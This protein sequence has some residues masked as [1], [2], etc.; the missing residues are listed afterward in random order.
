MNEDGSGLRA[1][2]GPEGMDE[3]PSWSPDGRSIAYSSNNEAIY[4]IDVEGGPRRRLT[5]V[6]FSTTMPAWRPA[7][8]EPTE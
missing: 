7:L 5:S 2:T 1:I 6:R 8:D 3:H 4:V